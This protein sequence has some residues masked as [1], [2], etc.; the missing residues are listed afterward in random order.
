MHVFESPLKLLLM[1]QCENTP[2]LPCVHFLEVRTH[3]TSPVICKKVILKQ[4]KKIILLLSVSVGAVALIFYINI[5]YSILLPH[6][7]ILK[8]HPVACQNGLYARMARRSIKPYGKPQLHSLKQCIVI[9]AWRYSCIV[10]CHFWACT[11]IW[12]YL[13]SYEGCMM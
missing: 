1:Y 12:T 8:P 7:M 9:K 3:I 5:I 4:L 13:V 6:P 2:I 10:K 11:F